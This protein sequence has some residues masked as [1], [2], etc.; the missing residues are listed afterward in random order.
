[1][2]EQGKYY[3]KAKHLHSFS[4]LSI[5][6]RCLLKTDDYGGLR[7]QKCFSLLRVK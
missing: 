2:C 6:G 5:M 1:M 3:Y 4:K 7:I